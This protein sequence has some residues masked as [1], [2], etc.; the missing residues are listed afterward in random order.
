[1]G[2]GSVIFNIIDKRKRRYRWKKITAIVEPTYHDNSVQDSDQTEIPDPGFSPY[3]Q[4]EEISLADA[5]IWATSLP[6]EA[7]LYL[8]DLGGGI[9]SAGK[10]SDLIK[11]N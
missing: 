10:L 2:G 1:M 5:V 11:P 6:Y 8:Y 4:R 9:S 3:D 7:T